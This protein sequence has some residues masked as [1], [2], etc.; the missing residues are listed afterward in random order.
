MQLGKKRRFNRRPPVKTCPLCGG[1][2]YAW[3]EGTACSRCK[4]E[5]APDR[6]ALTAELRARRGLREPGPL[7]ERRPGSRSSQGTDIGF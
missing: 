2:V 6:E 4:R 7:G 1:D 3:Q 5:Q